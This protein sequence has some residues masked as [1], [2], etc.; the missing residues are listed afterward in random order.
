VAAATFSLI[1][2]TW[3]PYSPAQPQ[4]RIAPLIPAAVAPS[5]PPGLGAVNLTTV[6]NAWGPPQGQAQ[7]SPRI[8]PIL[9]RIDAA[10]VRGN[11]TLT[12][13]IAAWTLPSVISQGYCEIA[14]NIAAVQQSNPPP[15]VMQIRAL[16]AWW[17]EP[18][19]VISLASFAAQVATADHP[20]VM[21]GVNLALIVRNWQRDPY[22]PQGYVDVAPLVPAPIAPDQPPVPGKAT[23]TLTVAS[24]APPLFIAQGAGDIAPNI[25]AQATPDSPP[26]R[27]NVVST[28]IVDAW[29]T[30]YAIDRRVGIAPLVSISQPLFASRAQLNSIIGSWQ[31]PYQVRQMLGQLAQSGPTVVTVD[32]ADAETLTMLT[33]SQMLSMDITDQLFSINPK[34]R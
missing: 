19:T 5:Q 22:P 20:P 12:L 4:A 27:G 16:S 13:T 25:A 10:P 23:L 33:D 17:T 24:W 29:R 3:Q 21:T 11:A 1:V 31:Q 32:Y 8:A 7:G 34:R 2:S 6:V 26:I 14:P 9:P 18:N 30:A 28:L 15:P